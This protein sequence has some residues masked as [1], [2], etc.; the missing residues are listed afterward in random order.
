[1]K[2]KYA[3]ILL[4]SITVAGS[5][6]P[7][8]SL[9]SIESAMYTLSDICNRLDS[10]V[11]GTKKA[12]MDPT[13]G[14]GSTGCTLNEMMDKA[15]A[16][17]NINGAQ[18]NDVVTGKTFWGLREGQWGMQMGQG[19]PNLIPSNIKAGVTLFGVVGTFSPTTSIEVA[20][21]LNRYVDN[22]DGTVTDTRSNL[23]WLKNAN[24]FGKQTW[25]EAIA[26]QKKILVKF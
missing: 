13:R 20:A 17:D 7:P 14:P 26:F 8:G 23:L 3:L 4:P 10:G 1:M 2:I 22:G 25:Y 18:P 21:N 6:E 24:C 16:K 15:P 9:Y 19:D 11:A 5:L 12:F